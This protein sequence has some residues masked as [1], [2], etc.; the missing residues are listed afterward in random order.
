MILA[1]EKWRQEAKR[2]KV[3]LAISKFKASLGYLILVSMIKLIKL[4][5]KIL[6]DRNLVSVSKP[7][8]RK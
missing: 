8:A 3:I 6:A 2:L 5:A 1:L 4:T 7:E